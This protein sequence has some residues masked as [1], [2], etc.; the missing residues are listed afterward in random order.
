MSD[1]DIQKIIAETSFTMEVEG[2]TI[3]PEEKDKIRKVL[4]GEI[5]FA[6]QL[7]EYIENAKRIG[8][9]QNASLQ[10]V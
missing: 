6:N 1:S 7:K 8:G 9:V 10:R 5:S 4:N 3:T 2:F